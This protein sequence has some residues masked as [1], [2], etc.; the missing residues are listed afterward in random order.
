MAI[1]L[2]GSFYCAEGKSLMIKIMYLTNNQEELDLAMDYAK[3]KWNFSLSKNAAG[4]GG[5]ICPD[6]RSHCQGP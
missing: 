2:S 3:K 4:P 6:V 5:R 1:K